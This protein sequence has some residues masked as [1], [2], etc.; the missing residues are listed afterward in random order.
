MA[1]ASVLFSVCSVSLSLCQSW[2]IMAHADA[3]CMPL[4][5]FCGRCPSCLSILN[6]GNFHTETETIG[7]GSDETKARTANR[8]W[9][10]SGCSSVIWPRILRLVS[11]CV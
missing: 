2:C 8:S 1:Y 3:V 5:A 10:L 4:V 11:Q 9:A 6:K 7:T